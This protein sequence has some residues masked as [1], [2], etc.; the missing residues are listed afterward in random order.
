MTT[1]EGNQRRVECLAHAIE[2]LELETFDPARILDHACDRECVMGG[3]LRKQAPA[4]SQELLHAR[5]EAEVGHRLAGEHR[6][7][8]EP[9]LLRALDLGV[10]IGA[11][12]EAHHQAAV[13]PARQRIDIVDHSVGALLIGLDREPKS[14]PA[15]ER[16]FAERC[17]DHVERKLKPVSFFGIDGE[18]QVESLGAPRQLVQA[19]HQLRH[20]AGAAHCLEPRMQRG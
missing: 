17:G 13:V 20:H 8:G 7:V 19:R 4:R 9:A 11:L 1:D 14:I 15:G 3:E 5:H 18:I 2:A 12:D 16:C 10:P 6:I